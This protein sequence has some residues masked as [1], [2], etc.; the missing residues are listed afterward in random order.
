MT[1]FGSP[2]GPWH[3]AVADT[4]D[5]FD[6]VTGSATA[7]DLLPQPLD[8]RIDGAVENRHVVTPDFFEQVFATEDPVRIAGE[9]AQQTELGRRQ[10]DLL[11]LTDDIVGVDID[12]QIGKGEFHGGI[13]LN[14]TS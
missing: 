11:S 5:R 12:H 9:D 7:P 3:K 8:M 14:G 13:L 10:G 6:V 4:P 1:R 2:G